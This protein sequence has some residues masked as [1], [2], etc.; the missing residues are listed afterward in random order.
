MKEFL[1]KEEHSLAERLSESN[2]QNHCFF[3]TLQA[4]IF[5][6][7]QK[8]EN[9]L[10]KNKKQHILKELKNYLEIRKYPY[11]E[12]EIAIEHYRPLL[13]CL[14]VNLVLKKLP[15]AA[16]NIFKRH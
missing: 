1:D 9:G 4:E 6:N 5:L 8:D 3:F 15:N 7:G 2:I 14:I 10:T 16:R 12:L 13:K 11:F